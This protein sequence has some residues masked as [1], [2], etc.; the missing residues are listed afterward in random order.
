MLQGSHGGSIP[1][2]NTQDPEIELFGP[3]ITVISLRIYG[4]GTS[5][6]ITKKNTSQTRTLAISTNKEHW[7]GMAAQI[8][9]MRGHGTTKAVPA[10]EA[11]EDI[12]KSLPIEKDRVFDI[13]LGLL[14]LNG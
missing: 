4:T 8:T 12:L 10:E 5:S 9:T 7:S 13:E 14:T 1:A 6:K 3:R 2:P 11:A